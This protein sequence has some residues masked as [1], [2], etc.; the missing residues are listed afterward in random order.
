MKYNIFL[1]IFSVIFKNTLSLC[2]INNIQANA[3]NIKNTMCDRVIQYIYQIDS[4]GDSQLT[5]DVT[6]KQSLNQGNIGQNYSQYILFATST[7]IESPVNFIVAQ[8]NQW[9]QN[10]MINGTLLDLDHNK[11]FIDRKDLRVVVNLRNSNL[12][13]NVYFYLIDIGLIDKSVPLSD[14]QQIQQYYILR[15]QQSC[16]NNCNNQGFCSLSTCKCSEGKIGKDCSINQIKEYP[17]YDRPIN[18]FFINIQNLTNDYIQKSQISISS[19]SKINLR[20]LNLQDFSDSLNNTLSMFSTPLQEQEKYSIN[21]QL[22]QLLSSYKNAKIIVFQISF[23]NEASAVSI[24]ITGKQGQQQNNFTIFYICIGS[25]SF[26]LVL[27]VVILIQICKY[28]EKKKK[29]QKELA[30]Q[31]IIQNEI[32]YYNE[33]QAQTKNHST[34]QSQDVKKYLPSTLFTQKIKEF[35]QVADLQCSVCLEDFIVGKDKIK[36][37]IC[38]HIFHDNCLDEWLNK[39]KNCPLCRQQHSLSQIKIHLEQK[40]KILQKNQSQSGNISF[41]NLPEIPNEQIPNI[42]LKIKNQQSVI[43]KDKNLHQQNQLQLNIDISE[44]Q[45]S[46]ILKPSAITLNSPKLEKQYSYLTQQSLLNQTP[47]KKIFRQRS[48][49]MIN[50]PLYQNSKQLQN[51]DAQIMTRQSS[52]EKNNLQNHTFSSIYKSSQCISQTQSRQIKA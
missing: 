36:V 20:M 30:R 47:Q 50:S 26:G 8:I 41:E 23:L 4:K 7:L 25:I 5:F 9:E 39:F 3:F 34:G 2:T 43:D 10:Q 19:D 16:L 35:Y 46:Q 13:K 38:S 40:S 22:E 28:K 12:G 45:N 15:T 33:I 17:L 11:Y 51:L 1:L 44:I 18:Y 49:L 31:Q 27:I 6:F 48:F 29:L 14:V 42:D 52:F 32:N 24:Q 37:T 21:L